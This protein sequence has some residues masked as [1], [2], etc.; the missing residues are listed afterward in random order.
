[1]RYKSKTGAVIDVAFNV[2]P[3]KGWSKLS[4]KDE[5]DE[6]AETMTSEQKRESSKAIA[7]MR[8][9]ARSEALKAIPELTGFI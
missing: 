8:V 7:N 9:R 4:K 5:F 3:P 2:K 1:M 6:M